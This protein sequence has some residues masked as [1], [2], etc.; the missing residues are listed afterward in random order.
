MIGA[1]MHYV[2]LMQSDSK[3]EELATPNPRSLEITNGPPPLIVLPIPIGPQCHENPVRDGLT[4]TETP[5]PSP[6]MWER[7]IARWTTSECA[8]SPIGQGNGRKA[9]PQNPIPAACSQVSQ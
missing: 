6:A 4:G 9:T 2:H 5:S 3:G 8:V 1:S 7:Q